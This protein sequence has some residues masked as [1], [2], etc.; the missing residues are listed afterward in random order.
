VLKFDQKTGRFTPYPVTT[1]TD[2]PKLAVTRDGTVWFA[3]RNAGE[4]GD[5]GGAVA[6]LFPD[7]DGIETFAAYYAADH[8][9]NRKASH[10]WPVT[11]VTGR[12]ILVPAAPQNP[13]EF[14]NAVGFAATRSEAA[15]A[16]PGSVGAIKGGA[17]RE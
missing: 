8:P 3:A 1:R 13:C 17:A 12:R 9:R 10:E 7:K 15:T 6:A 16:S 14:A 4:S 2:I 11:A 5:Y